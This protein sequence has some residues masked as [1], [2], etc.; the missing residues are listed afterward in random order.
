ME[1]NQKPQLAKEI[2][3]NISTGF[4]AGIS[5]VQKYN[6]TAMWGL[7]SV[8]EYIFKT[9]FSGYYLNKRVAKTAYRV[10]S[11]TM[12][13][14]RVSKFPFAHKL[15]KSL[16]DYVTNTEIAAQHLHSLGEEQSKLVYE[17]IEEKTLEI[18]ANQD[19]INEAL[20]IRGW[21]QIDFRDFIIGGYD[22]E[23]NQL[24][25]SMY[26]RTLTL[27][28]NPQLIRNAANILSSLVVEKKPENEVQKFVNRT[29]LTFVQSRE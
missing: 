11:P 19:G 18:L 21:T 5:T 17:G 23:V 3:K 12:E 22:P 15:V 29:A 26:E 14:M 2:E 4:T 9:H 28:G 10:K 7:N 24:Y 1:S 8:T 16:E 25:R 6:L 27:F 13:R 20:A